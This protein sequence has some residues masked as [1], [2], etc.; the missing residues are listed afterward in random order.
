MCCWGRHGLPA[1]DCVP[2]CR[3]SAGGEGPARRKEQAVRTALGGS[4]LRL[5]RQHLMESLLA[6]GMRRRG[7]RSA[8]HWVIQWVVHTRHDMVRMEAIHLD[9]VAVA[10]AA[11]LVVLCALFSGLFLH[12]PPRATTF[13]R[14]LQESSR[15]NSAGHGRTRLRAVLLSL[16]VGLTVVLLIGGGIVAEELCA[17]ALGGPW[18]HDAECAENDLL[19]RRRATASPH[20]AQTSS[21]ALLERVRNLPGVEAAGFVSPVVPGERLRRRQRLQHSRTSGSSAGQALVCPAS[22]DRPRLFRRHRHSDSARG[23]TFDGTQQPGHA[24]EVI[25]SDAFAPSTFPEKIQLENSSCR[26]VITHLKSWE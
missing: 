6:L 17:I 22:L 24:T 15:A 21:M 16:E 14:P 8:G 2:Q 26:L 5:L 4:R 23:H 20:S 12:S 13:S 9:G 18:V 19:C 7:R 1:V 11:G 10:F 25:I 3:Q